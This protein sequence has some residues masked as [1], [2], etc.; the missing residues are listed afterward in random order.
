MR[1]MHV[2]AHAHTLKSIAAL[3]V[4]IDDDR[5]RTETP[6]Q[7]APPR[8]KRTLSG[9]GGACRRVRLATSA[10]FRHRPAVQIVDVAQVL[11]MHMADPGVPMASRASL[12]L[13]VCMHRCVHDMDGA[14]NSVHSMAAGTHGRDFLDR[15]QHL[16][17]C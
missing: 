2:R 1:G 13:S 11:P 6:A 14:P 5:E 9:A 4:S 7:E 16:Q 10:T 12:S 17:Q 3:D 8:V 15:L